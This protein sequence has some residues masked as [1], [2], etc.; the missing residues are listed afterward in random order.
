MKIK[1]RLLYIASFVFLTA[2]LLMLSSVE[3]FANTNPT[4]TNVA[5]TISGTTVTVT[6][7]VADAEESTFT[8]YMEV[9]DD[10]GTTWDFDYGATT[11]DIGPN[12]AAGN[13]KTIT[14][15]YT[16]AENSNFIIKI[17]ADDL[18]GDQEYYQGNIFDIITYSGQDYK[19]ITI[20]TQTW[21]AENLNVGTKINSTTNGFEQTDNSIMEKYCYNNNASNCDT[22]GGLYEW[23]EAMQYVTTEGT[24]G[25]CPSGWHIP[26]LAE[27]QTLETYVVGDRATKLIDENARSGYTYT[28]ETGFSALFAGY[29][30]NYTGYFYNLGR[31]TNFWS[32]TEYGSVAG[33]ML[34]RSNYSYVYFYYDDKSH[35]F[36]VRCLKD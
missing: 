23:T 24:Q 11:G 6:Y 9:S 19:T 16:G 8:V 1:N 5:F 26:T 10:G 25:I 31:Y 4:V 20:G 29:R 17:L 33:N 21:F 18:F 12:V 15:E 35:G 13:T 36:S 7:D 14:W 22:Y 28:N 2:Q 3:V 32:S 27:Y 34:L 30:Y